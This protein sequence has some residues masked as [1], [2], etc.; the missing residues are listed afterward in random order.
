MVYDKNKWLGVLIML[1]VFVSGCGDSTS[2]GPGGSGTPTDTNIDFN[3]FPDNYF[4]DYAASANLTGSDNLGNTYTGNAAEKTL[5]ETTFLGE[6][7]IPIE[8]K[9][10]FNASNGGFAAITQN[11]YFNT[12]ASDRRFLGIDGDIVTVSASTA[13]IPATARIGDSGTAGTYTD[14]TGSTSTLKWSLEDGFNGNAKLIF[15]TSTTAPSG[16]LDNTFTTTYLIQPD[17]TRLSVEIKTFN[18]TVG[19][20][21][22]LSGNY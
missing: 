8:V 18:A 16:A 12:N 7:A 3:L 19:M 13:A 1:G 2:P 20:E 17:G 22:T 4:A 11:Q 14:N 21:V 15:L 5:P 6:S 9:I 10:S